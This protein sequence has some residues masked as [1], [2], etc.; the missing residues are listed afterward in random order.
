VTLRVDHGELEETDPHG[1]GLWLM[2]WKGEFFTG[3]AFT[4]HGDGSLAS[5][6]PFV[7]GC[8]HGR[9]VDFAKSGQII[10]DYAMEHG[11]S[12]GQDRAWWPDGTP[13]WDRVRG[14]HPDYREHRWNEAGVLVSERD[15][16]ARK[17]RTWYDDGTLRRERL[18]DIARAFGPDG[19]LL[20]TQLRQPNGYDI[21]Q[22]EDDAMEA[23]IEAL[24]VDP[25]WWHIALGY[26]RDLAERERAR[27]V[28]QLRRVLGGENRVA[29]VDAAQVAGAFR[30]VELAQELEA[31][32]RDDTKVEMVRIG[33]GAR[34]VSITIGEA[35]RRALARLNPA[36]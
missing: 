23:S 11:R 36:Q 7:D 5:E 10:R 27:G 9:C 26:L 32:S 20:F 14:R 4:L 2:T 21:T 28:A 6:I 24:L 25:D 22:F 16:V 18:G 13:R 30:L 31:L 3:M 17:N 33:P 19:R 12:V 1:E 29:K 35:A 8:A 15:D 34:G